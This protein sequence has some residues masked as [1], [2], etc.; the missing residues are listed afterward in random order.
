MAELCKYRGNT[1]ASDHWAKILRKKQT[2]YASIKDLNPMYG[3]S[4]TLASVA[5]FFLPH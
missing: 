1:F 4:G 3:I 5:Y 2:F